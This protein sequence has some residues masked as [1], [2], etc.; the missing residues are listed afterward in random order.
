MRRSPIKFRVN[1]LFV[2]DCLPGSGLSVAHAVKTPVSKSSLRVLGGP[3]LPLVKPKTANPQAAVPR[4]RARNR[5]VPRQCAS[6]SDPAAA[7]AVGCQTMRHFLRP[8]LLTLIWSLFRGASAGR[9]LLQPLFH[10]N[11][12]LRPSQPRTTES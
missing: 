1:G 8:S 9:H 12:K 3:S 10:P 6:A 2:C 5:K 11:P 4:T 7:P